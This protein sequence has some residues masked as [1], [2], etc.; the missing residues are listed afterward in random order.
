MQIFFRQ[1]IKIFANEKH[2]SNF[3]NPKQKCQGVS[4]ILTFSGNSCLQLFCRWRGWLSS[5]QWKG[6]R[7]SS[8][9]LTIKVGSLIFCRR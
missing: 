6:S 1:W 9:L 5:A 4:D 2:G 7:S 8:W 3:Q